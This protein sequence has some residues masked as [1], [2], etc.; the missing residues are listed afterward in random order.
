DSYA[1]IGLYS[2]ADGG[3]TWELRAASAATGVPNRIG[4]IA[5]D[6]FDSQHLRLGGLGQQPQ[7]DVPGSLGGMFTS[8][9]GGHTWTRETFIATENYWCHA[10]VFDSKPAGRIYATFTER[11]AKNG[12]W[13]SD[14]GGTSWT[15][16]V[17]GL[18][19]PDHM[20]RTALAIA[21]SDP[22]VLYTQA[23][24]RTDH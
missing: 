2:T 11:G 17:K 9:D 1:G 19:A 6:P 12:I 8:R 18:P 23:A 3:T 16:L 24:T 5:V 22:K 7:D 21:P 14:D 13:R 20:D 4:A 15:H 10:I